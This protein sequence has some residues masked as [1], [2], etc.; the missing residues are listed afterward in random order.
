MNASNFFPGGRVIA[1]KI[2][3]EG[4]TADHLKRPLEARDRRKIK[5][6]NNVMGERLT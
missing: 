2:V 1:A 6:Q 3:R 5:R 4:G